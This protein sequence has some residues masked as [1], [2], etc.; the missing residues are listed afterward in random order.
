MLE[1]AQAVLGIGA[2]DVSDVLAN[3]LGA[4]LGTAAAAMLAWVRPRSAPGRRPD[5]RHVLGWVGIWVAGAV[6]IVS[7]A[8]LL[9]AQR[10]RHLQEVLAGAFDGST[11]VDY[12]LWESQDLLPAKVFDIVSPRADG[13]EQHPDAV[14]VRYPAAV[15]GA[16]RCALVS[17]RADGVS[18]TVAK[19]LAC[20]RFLG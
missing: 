18:T 7:S 9:A 16:R 2:N 17:W 12:R 3:A 13:V 8:Q 15:L 19:G 4:G 5:R 11:L 6:L 14:M 1:M 10:A 20:T